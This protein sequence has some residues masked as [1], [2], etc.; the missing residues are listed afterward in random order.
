MFIIAIYL[1][2]IF[3]FILK[4]NSINQGIKGRL[5]GLLN[6]SFKTILKIEIKF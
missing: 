1:S 3:N 2:I 4:I 5:G 6:H